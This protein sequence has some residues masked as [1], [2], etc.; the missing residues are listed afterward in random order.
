MAYLQKSNSISQLSLAKIRSYMAGNS[1]ELIDAI[2]KVVNKNL[3]SS[4]SVISIVHTWEVKT[5]ITERTS[6]VILEQKEKPGES[7]VHK[8]EPK[9]L[10]EFSYEDLKAY[11]VKANGVYSGIRCGTIEDHPC[12]TKIEC[13]SCN[14]T[15]ICRTCE[16]KKQIT[17][18]VCE[19]GKECISCNGTGTYTCENC[20]GDGECPECDNGWYTCDECYGE[21][22]VTCPDC[23][24]S[25]N[26]IDETCNSCGGSGY[27]GNN[28]CRTCHGTGRFVR[29]CRRCDGEGTIDCENCNGDGGWTCKECHGSGKCS[30]CHGEGGFKCKACDGTGK[31]GKCKGKGKIWCPDCH[32]KGVCFE[33][34]GEKEITCPRCGGLGKYQ[35]FTEYSI[36]KEERSEKM[37]C[38]LPI[39]NDEI[40]SIDG[41]ACFNGVVYDFFAKKANVFAV[42]S[43]VNSLHDMNSITVKKWLS[44][45]NYPSYNKKEIPNDYMVIHAVIF[46]I[47]TSKIVLKCN[48]KE[49]VIYIVGNNLT[50]YYDRLPSWGA[51]LI[52][53]IRKL[54]RK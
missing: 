38:S 47:P 36:S 26:Y 3:V 5:K 7:L 22:K 44:L 54:V 6:K 18:P 8:D 15:G 14:G 2:G 10:H 27:Y 37:L 46:K 21:G 19:G 48:S 41:D 12:E 9:D 31:C 40:P 35:S 28:E 30:H 11:G 50:V 34:K 24:G 33:C 43:A 53:R 1:K 23:G 4:C 16:G 25:G 17:C 20:E 49:Y 45:E 52:G 51:G 42:D 32:G 29:E 39:K 13:P